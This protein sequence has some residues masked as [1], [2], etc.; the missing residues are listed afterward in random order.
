MYFAEEGQKDPIKPRPYDA[1]A[2]INPFLDEIA[3]VENWMSS[4]S[5]TRGLT[6]GPPDRDEIVSTRGADNQLSNQ[7]G[8]LGIQNYYTKGNGFFFVEVEEVTSIKKDRRE[9]KHY[10]VK[11]IFGKKAYEATKKRADY[12]Y[13]IKAAERTGLGFAVAGL[14]G[15]IGTAAQTTIDSIWSYAEGRQ[16]PNGNLVT[17]DRKNISTVEDKV[18]DTYHAFE[19]ADEL[20]AKGM[21]AYK[22]SEG[23][24]LIYTGNASKV[25]TEDDAIMFETDQ[26][27]IDHLYGLLYEGAIT[28]TRYTAGKV[29]TDTKIIKEKCDPHGG[30]RKSGIGGTG[31]AVGGGHSGGTG[32][33]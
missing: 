13:L 3:G 4:K 30:G 33:G 5:K 7:C 31:G 21:I 11:L 20:S 22:H 9:N 26:T 2:N 6:Y 1:T 23:I 32:G 19:N 8:L 15:A 17:D 10:T 12:V 29:D 28:V 24:A 16:V 25:R 18:A 27:G 14:G